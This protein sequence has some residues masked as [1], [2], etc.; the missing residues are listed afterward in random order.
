MIV[1]WD[2]RDVRAEDETSAARMARVLWERAG[3]FSEPE[4]RPLHRATLL[5]LLVPRSRMIW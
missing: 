2:A 1:E 5:L 4:R 3:A